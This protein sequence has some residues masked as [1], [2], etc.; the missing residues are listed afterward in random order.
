MEELWKV[1]RRVIGGYKQYEG[2]INIGLKFLVGMFLFF[3]MGMLSMGK[4]SIN[5][6]TLIALIFSAIMV[7]SSASGFYM[8]VL[9]AAGIYLF[10]ASVETALLVVMVLFLFLVFYVRLFPKQSLL[11][12]ALFLA[13]YFKVPFAV[14][15]FAGIYVGIIGIVPISIGVFLWSML[16]AL[17]QFVSIA[18]KSEFTP[19]G[20]P[21]AFIRIYVAACEYFSANTQWFLHAVIFSLVIIVTCVIAHFAMNFAKEISIGAGACIFLVVYF[22][23]NLL[24]KSD[25]TIISVF[26]GIIGSLILLFLI[27]LFEDIPDYP[28]AEKVEFEDDYNY[29]YVKVIPKCHIEEVYTAEER[30][31]TDLYHTLQSMKKRKRK[32][33]QRQSEGRNSSKSGY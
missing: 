21:D 18:P 4:L 25:Y 24:K 14:P 7:V 6:I 16:P 12:P 22:I 32:K 13:Y 5:K 17:N 15:I 19:L 31:S 29:Y 9:I 10:F 8:L 26:L 33:F 23:A 1:R 20:M 2:P 27:R 11:I 28:R 3:K 30:N